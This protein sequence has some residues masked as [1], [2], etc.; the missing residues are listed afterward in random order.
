MIS[1]DGRYVAFG[2]VS[3]NLFPNDANGGD[4]DIVVSAVLRPEIDSVA[5]A[6]LVRGTST[7]LTVRGGWFGAD[8]VAALGEGI[9]VRSVQL[10]DPTTLRVSVD[11]SATAVPGVRSVVVAEPGSGPG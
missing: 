8:A 10:A 3:S 9:V 2:T 11:I 5:P 1:G 7:V 4:F 6:H